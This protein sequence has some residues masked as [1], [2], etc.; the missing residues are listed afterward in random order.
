MT[1]GSQ[2]LYYP[3]PAKPEMRDLAGLGLGLT[4]DLISALS[5]FR[6]LFVIAQHT[7]LAQ[8]LDSVNTMALGHQLGTRYL[9]DGSIRTVGRGFRVAV[10]LIDTVS[11]GYLWSESYDGGNQE[12]LSI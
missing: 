10:Q 11:G 6:Q 7:S 4:V 8:K 12:L 3:L 9:V 5:R 2:S 1:L